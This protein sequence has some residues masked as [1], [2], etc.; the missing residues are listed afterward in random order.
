MTDGCITISYWTVFLIN[1][2]YFIR[3]ITDCAYTQ[4]LTIKYIFLK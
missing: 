4:L 1:N 3:L 2:T